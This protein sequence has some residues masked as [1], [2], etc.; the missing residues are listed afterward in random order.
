MHLADRGTARR[1]TRLR[2]AARLAHHLS[3]VYAS[4]RVRCPRLG[5]R[6]RGELAA[7]FAR[8]MLDA[9]GVRAQVRGRP[10]PTTDPVLVVANH[11]SW[12]DMYALNAV[13]GARFVAKSE[14]RGWPFFGT[15]AE[16][17]DTLF[18]VRGSYRDAA[19]MR[20]EVARV[21]RAGARVVVFP[22]GTTSDGT[23]VG[24]FHPA[25]FQSAI[26][27]RAPVQP[28]AIRYR[29]ARGGPSP[30]PVF[31]G[32]TTVLESVGRVIREPSLTVE[33]TFG[34]PL[35][36]LG[37]TRKALA[38]RTRRWIAGQLG[39]REGTVTRRRF[40]A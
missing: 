9:L 12:L 30:A 34:P 15:I 35:S 8:E 16:R 5:P 22:E 14:V 31:V 27:A 26:D 24:H 40:A 33:V 37:L 25:L 20:T 32:D 18:I 21:L 1:S 2:R 17:F 3:R 10:Y 6:A 4:A 19:R 7:A 11:V 13:A 39:I 38:Q 28:V 23:T 29:D 36:P